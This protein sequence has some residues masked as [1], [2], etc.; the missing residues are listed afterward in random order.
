MGEVDQKSKVREYR[1]YDI[2]GEANLKKSFPRTLF[3]IAHSSK[4]SLSIALA[5]YHNSSTV[6]RFCYNLG[7]KKKKTLLV[8]PI[9]KLISI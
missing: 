2:F 9:F 7:M 5:V 6:E 3:V 4:R 1:E 8:S